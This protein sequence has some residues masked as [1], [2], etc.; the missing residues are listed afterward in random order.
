MSTDVKA[1]KRAHQG[2]TAEASED[3]TKDMRQLVASG[4]VAYIPKPDP[5]YLTQE[6]YDQ[7][8]INNGA[9]LRSK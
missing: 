8:L 2:A 3:E 7:L 4:A 1:G 5:I 6:Q 9:Q